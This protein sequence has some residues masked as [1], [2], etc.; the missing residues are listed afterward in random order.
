MN[1][2]FDNPNMYV[3][4]TGKRLSPNDFA[5]PCGLMAKAYFNGIE[6]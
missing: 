6:L 3:T 1:E 2:M 4:Y 5:N